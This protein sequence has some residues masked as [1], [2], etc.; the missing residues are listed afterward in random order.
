MMATT[1]YIFPSARKVSAI[2]AF[3]PLASAAHPVNNN[4]M[5]RYLMNGLIKFKIF[6]YQRSITDSKGSDPYSNQYPTDDCGVKDHP[7]AVVKII[8]I[9]PRISAAARMQRILEA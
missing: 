6:F 9:E 2:S 7:H 3:W 1:T 8:N 5:V 4:N